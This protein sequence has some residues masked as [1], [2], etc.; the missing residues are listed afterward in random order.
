MAANRETA[1]DALETLIEAACVGTG[2]PVQAT[3]NYRV[4][5]FAGAS[6]VVVVSSRGSNRR[7]MTLKGSRAKFYLQVDVL[8]LYALE[9]GTW[10]EAQAE[11]ALDRIESLIAGVVTSNQATA[12]WGALSYVGESIRTDV[13]IGGVEYIRESVVLEAEVYA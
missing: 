3:Y 10:T 6:P 12:A 11:D 1:R 7:Q 13:M 5:D 4:G 9:D 2:L 8:V